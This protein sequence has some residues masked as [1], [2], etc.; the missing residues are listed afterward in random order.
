MTDQE[1]VMSWIEGLAQDDWRQFHSDSEVSNIAKAALT[2][3]KEQEPA[4][5]V[6]KKGRWFTSPMCR[7]CGYFFQTGTKPNYCQECGQMVKWDGS[8]AKGE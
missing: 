7:K 5:P 3:L 8:F 4:E 1:K 2:L 6:M